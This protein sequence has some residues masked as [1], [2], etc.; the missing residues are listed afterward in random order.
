MTRGPSSYFVNTSREAAV[1][2]F[3]FFELNGIIVLIVK[4]AQIMIK[5]IWVGLSYVLWPWSTPESQLLNGSEHSG[6]G[7]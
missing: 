5:S 1:P 6:V 7:T 2:F 4:H 3:F